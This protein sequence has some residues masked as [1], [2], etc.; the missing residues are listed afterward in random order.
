MM[1]DLP[2]KWNTEAGFEA[3]FKELY[4]PLHRYA[5]GLIADEQQAEELVQDVFLKLWQQ[6]DQIQIASNVQAYLYRAVHNNAMNLLNHEKVKAKYQ[7]YMKTRT[8]QYADSPSKALDVKELKEQI[9]R[10][11]DK[12]PE[13]CRAIFFLSRQESL[14]YRDIAGQLGISIK[15]V[16]NQMSKALKILREELRDYLPFTAILFFLFNF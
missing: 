5:S 11:M 8:A 6:K 2:G 12:I 1:Q 14:S 9:F 16:E 15:T 3:L 4:A 13:K 10:A 7:T